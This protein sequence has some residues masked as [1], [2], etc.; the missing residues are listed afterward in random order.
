MQYT[1]EE[2]KQL[3]VEMNEFWGSLNDTQSKMVNR[4]VANAARGG[5]Y[6]TCVVIEKLGMV[7]NS[8]ELL[9]VVQKRIEEDMAKMNSTECDKEE[10]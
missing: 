5:I 10:E 1:E 9:Q 6:V 4:L 7:D 3:D 8:E 2:L